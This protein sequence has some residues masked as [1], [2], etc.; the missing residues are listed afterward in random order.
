LSIYTYCQTEMLPSSGVSYSGYTTEI[1]GRKADDMYITI[2]PGINYSAVVI[3]ND[4]PTKITQ[5]PLLNLKLGPY[6]DD[7]KIQFR[8]IAF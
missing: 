8:N 3:F 1:G 4:I 5:V 7:P 2:S 6:D